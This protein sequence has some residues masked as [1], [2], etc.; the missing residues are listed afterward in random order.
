MH[1][2][3]AIENK[4]TVGQQ[5]HG[6]EVTK[7]EEIPDVRAVAIELQHTKS[8]AQLLH[9]L[10][11]DPENLFAIAFRTPPPDDTGLPHILEHTVLC[12][13]KKYPVKDPFVELLKT[14]LASFLNA[15][16]YPDKTVYPCASMNRQDFFNLAG[17]YCDAAFR[18]LITEMHFKQEGHHLEFKTPGDTSSELTING[19][20]YNEM[21]GA[22][23]NLDG[24]IDR[25]EM[26]RICPD[27]A[28]GL[29]SGGDPEAIPTL[30]Y[31]DFK[32]FH[33][34]YY[35][36]A[37]SRIFIYGDI[38]TEEHL[39]FL[40][41]EYLSGYD[42]IE[43]DSSISTQPRWSQPRSAQIPYP[44]SADDDINKK[45]AV[46]ITWL[47]N[48]VTDAIT[49]LAMNIIENYLLGNASSP[50]RRALI[51][52]KLGQELTSAGYADFQRDT[53]FT[54][55]LKGTSP[56]NAQKIEELVR[57]VCCKEAEQ[58][59]NSG[60]VEAAFHQLEMSALEIRPQYPLRLMDRVYR[61]WL[62]DAEPA[63][64]LKLASHLEKLRKLYN[65]QP[66][67]LE[68]ILMSQV[69]DNLHQITLTFVPEADY[70]K[71][72]A[73]IFARKMETVKSEMSQQEL[74]DIAKQQQEL[75]QM[76]MTPNSAEALATLPRL[77]LEN[78]P[79]KPLEPAISETEISGAPFMRGEV[80]T[81]GINYLTLAFDISDFTLEEL[82]L[83]PLY[84]EI[85][86][87]MGAAGLDY[88]S[89]AQK[90]AACC[91]GVSATIDS[92]GKVYDPQLTQP[93]FQLSVRGLERNTARM[94][95]ILEQRIFEPDFTDHERMKDVI[96]QSRMQLH[97]AL[98]PR[99]NSFAALYA[100]RS[101]SPNAYLK[102]RFAGF[103]VV[104]LFDKHADNFNADELSSAMQSI[105]KK[106]T[107]G[108]RLRMSVGGNDESVKLMQEWLEKTISKMGSTPI[109]ACALDLPEIND[110][111]AGIA[112]PCD[113]AFV[114]KAFPSIPAT[115]ELSA[116]L[117]VISLNL[118]FGYLWNEVRVKRGAYGCRAAHNGLHGIYGFSSY[119][120]PSINETFEVYDNAFSY[121]LNEMDLSKAGLEQA[122]IGTV[123]TLDIPWRPAQV[124][125][126][127][128]SRNISGSTY[129]SRYEFRQR[130][131]D[132]DVEKIR[133]AVNEILLPESKKSACCV[134]SSNEKLNVANTAGLELLIDKL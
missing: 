41:R 6:F 84:C 94:L 39:K 102:E 13:S 1:F 32:N 17:V 72:G 7:V 87:G 105:Q 9:L 80:F 66:R 42:R 128:M 53:F 3:S 121:I 124:V 130:L 40:D 2:M 129:E 99:G 33:A 78:I 55:G 110:N 27:N 118:S 30:S 131:L 25:E 88:A 29:D 11:D 18:P 97:S 70:N 5:L 26:R 21:K 95:E 35:H 69:V 125:S 68:E 20:V 86:T 52:S 117:A 101:F 44:A 63:H 38:P 92:T 31:E 50:L 96:Q 82:E 71:R 15:M 108:K 54:V 48:D 10:A 45:S 37:N 93:Y 114:A 46:T 134:L 58:G 103:S 59:F 127:A 65:D 16:T 132:L 98:V 113:V 106:L 120:D 100:S 133:K 34:R 123:K 109:T 73:E 49:S 76:Q 12:G 116:A 126:A 28:Y 74:E 24:V 115:H 22:Y 119:R 81:G 67:F 43:I 36:P 14:S 75:N 56:H 89:F 91:S 104:R 47:T 8:G 83:M 79:T 57:A 23:S 19:I 64:H 51:E 111:R 122:I 60:M 90:E 85:V 112:V 77:Q 4:L 61:S 107:Q 62:Y